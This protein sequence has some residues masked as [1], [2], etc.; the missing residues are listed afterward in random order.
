VN[1][2]CLNKACTC[3]QIFLGVIWNVYSS[4]ANGDDVLAQVACIA[5]TWSQDAAAVDA[6]QQL[7]QLK[8]EAR[9]QGL[10]EAEA[11]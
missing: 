2:M 8:R 10:L 9:T 6:K 7:Q 1:L 11:A 5:H 4:V 3:H